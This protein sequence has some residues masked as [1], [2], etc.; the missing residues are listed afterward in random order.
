MHSMEIAQSSSIRVW[1]IWCF[2]EFTIEQI[3]WAEKVF[4]PILIVC[5]YSFLT[6]DMHARND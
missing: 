4:C 2:F 5:Q 3:Y 1:K 6:N